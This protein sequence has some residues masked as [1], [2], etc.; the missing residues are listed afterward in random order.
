[1]RV[2]IVA[3]GKLKEKFYADAVAEYVKRCARFA[4]V[5]IAEV[6]DY[7]VKESEKSAPSLAMEK[8]A[9]AI[10]PLLSGYV[11]VL[12]IA[13]RTMSSPDFAQVLQSGF[14]K[15]GTVTFVI[16][17]SYGLSD[18]VKKRADLRLSFGPATFPHQLARVM[19][20]EQVYR[21]LTI[22]NHLPYHK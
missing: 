10:L 18:R 16:G 8:E 17:G 5:S 19:L 20:A 6:S 11:V 14:E 1:M 12:D 21:G 7:R 15:A 2:Q 3:V 4:P 22:L 13:G 9:D